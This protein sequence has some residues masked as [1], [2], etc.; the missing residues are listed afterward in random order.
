MKNIKFIYK[1]VTMTTIM[2]MVMEMR[3]ITRK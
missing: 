1:K 3:D 2:V